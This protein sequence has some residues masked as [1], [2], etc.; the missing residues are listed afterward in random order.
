MKLEEEIKQ[1][2]FKNPFHKLAVNILFTSNWL[3]SLHNKSLKKYGISTQQFNIL[4]ILRGQFPNAANVSLLVERML[5]KS[6]NVTRLLDKLVAKELVTRESCPQDRRKFNI[7]ITQKGLTL[8][9]TMDVEI[10]D[11]ENILN[12]ISEE[13]ANEVNV[14]LDRLRG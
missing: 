7:L 10:N 5:D 1:K 14:I 13:E 12:N 9:G 6:S 11:I 4:R 8:L 2:A 3:S